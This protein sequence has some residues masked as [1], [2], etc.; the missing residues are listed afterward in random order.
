M[1]T[2]IKS[3]PLVINEEVKNIIKGKDLTLSDIAE[4]ESEFWGVF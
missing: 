2:E 4:D 1:A 3:L